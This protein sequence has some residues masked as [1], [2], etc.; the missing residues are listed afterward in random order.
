MAR[1]MHAEGVHA[2]SRDIAPLLDDGVEDGEVGSHLSP[3][4]RHQES[5][6]RG[7]GS[8]AIEFRVPYLDG[9]EGCDRRGACRPSG[10]TRAGDAGHA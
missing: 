8:P 10:S 7:S 5:P 6:A 9:V 2:S 3:G 1:K 4:A